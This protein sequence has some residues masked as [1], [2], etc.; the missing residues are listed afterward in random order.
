MQVSA[1]FI[2]FWF[3]GIRLLL[4]NQAITTHITKRESEKD[5]DFCWVHRGH[6]Y[7]CELGN[8][9][10]LQDKTR[11]CNILLQCFFG[12]GS[13]FV[14]WI[15]VWNCILWIQKK[16]VNLIKMVKWTKHYH[17]SALELSSPF[18]PYLSCISEIL[19]WVGKYAERLCCSSSEIRN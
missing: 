6:L 13:D 7:I 4:L 16:I 3:F 2:T 18:S 5:T 11:M 1:I 12:P 10:F 19:G 14:E 17:V 9:A 8:Y 15:A